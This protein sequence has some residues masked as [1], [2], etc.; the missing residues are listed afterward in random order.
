MSLIHTTRGMLTGASTLAILA[1]G[2]ALSAP[3]QAVAEHA[4]N[5]PAS[6]VPMEV[7]YDFAGPTGNHTGSASRMLDPGESIIGTTF[8]DGST[9]NLNFARI[10]GGFRATVNNSVVGR[11]EIDRCDRY[12]GTTYIEGQDANVALNPEQVNVIN[13]Q[14]CPPVSPA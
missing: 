4:R 1:S 5:S 9:L 13:I 11:Y 7:T 10:P 2:I 14:H 3:A 8:A 6:V 12:D